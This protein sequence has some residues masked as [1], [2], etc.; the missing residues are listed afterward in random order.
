MI[1]EAVDSGTNMLKLTSPYKVDLCIPVWS[2]GTPKQF[3]VLLQQAL[4]SIRQKGLET[5]LEK[6]VKEKEECRKKLTKASEALKTTRER[7]RICPKR[8]Q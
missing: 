3:L 5:A 4:D 2:K 7:M 6:A 1:Q 8:K